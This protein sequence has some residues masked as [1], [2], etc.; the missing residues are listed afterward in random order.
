MQKH[1]ERLYQAQYNMAYFFLHVLRA[2]LK[3][4]A[5]FILNEVTE[6]GF[7]FSSVNIRVSYSDLFLLRNSKSFSDI[8][9]K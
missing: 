5:T 6:W 8:S 9:V 1:N 7:W 2:S 3:A 4:Y